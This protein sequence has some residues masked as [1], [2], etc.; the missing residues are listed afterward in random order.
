MTDSDHSKYL[1]FTT[2]TPKEKAIARFLER[3]HCEPVKV[4]ECGWLLWVG[5]V[6]EKEGAG[7]D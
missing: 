2:D 5:P 7:S 4:F 1:T 6:P 3:F